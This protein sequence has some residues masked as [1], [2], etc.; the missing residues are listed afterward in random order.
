VNA[1]SI[2]A[3]IKRTRVSVFLAQL[4]IGTRSVVNRRVGAVLAEIQRAR[5]VVIKFLKRTDPCGIAAVTAG[6]VVG[7]HATDRIRRRIAGGADVICARVEIVAMGVSGT[8]AIVGIG[9]R[10]TGFR[11]GQKTVVEV[12]AAVRVEITDA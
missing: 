2:V 7:V 8:I 12:D 5:I 1:L 9:R 11:L 6:H 4:V 3:K 10:T